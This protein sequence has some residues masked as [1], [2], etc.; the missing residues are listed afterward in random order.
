MKRYLLGMAILALPAAGVMW[1]AIKGQGAATP[2]SAPKKASTSESRAMDVGVPAS[3]NAAPPP[4]PPASAMLEEIGD[5]GLPTP[6]ASTLGDGQASPTLAPYAAWSVVRW[7]MA[8]ADVVTELKQAGF[9]VEEA[10]ETKSAAQRLRAKS[11]SRDLTVDF[12]AS[13]PS[14]IVVT[15]AS[16]SKEEVD[17]AVAK[18]KARAPAT[19]TVERSERRWK[20]EGDAV[21]SLSTEVDGNKAT[22]REEHVR[23]RAPGGW[24][25]FA[26]LR[27]GMSTAE[28]VGY[29]TAAGYAA[30]VVKAP[31][32]DADTVTFTKG[33]AEGSATFNQFGLRRVESSG[34]VTDGGEARTKELES[35]FGKAAATSVSTKT[36]HVDHGRMTAIDVE[37]TE[38]Q[39]SGGFTVTE[40]YRP[41]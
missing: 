35:S 6:D 24:V 11:G 3:V 31:A 14:Q 21:A 9:T 28:V 32:G 4:P 40:T 38:K 29:V 37:V 18:I 8:R 15:A 10:A 30:H 22:L 36:Q 41:K 13:G 20:M 2:A 27:W 33:D 23:E 5:A 34:P 19:N 17:A 1:V 25:G 12:G 39:P 26:K 16:L 7:G